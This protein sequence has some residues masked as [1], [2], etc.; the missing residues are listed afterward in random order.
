MGSECIVLINHKI[1]LPATHLLTHSLS[2]LVFRALQIAIFTWLDSTNACNI[3]IQR[4]LSMK[5]ID[6]MKIIKKV[7]INEGQSAIII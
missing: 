4:F 6:L 1:N 2:L 7:S 3:H 5:E